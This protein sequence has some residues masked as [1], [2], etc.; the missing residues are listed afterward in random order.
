MNRREFMAGAGASAILLPGVA[1]ALTPGQRVTLLGGANAYDPAA[2]AFFSRLTTPPTSARK[3][4]YNNFFK[5]LR[6]AGLLTKG[7]FCYLTAAADN[8]AARQNLLANQY[9][10]T[11][12]SSP[13]FTADQGYAGDGA[14]A[15]LDTNSVQSSFGNAKQNSYSLFVWSRTDVAADNSYDS[16]VSNSNNTGVI[17]K[18]STGSQLLCRTNSTTPTNPS[19]A[20]SLGF[21]GWTRT[22][23]TTG[24]VYKNRANVASVSSTSAALTAGSI[25]IL[26][27]ASLFSTRQC[28]FAW[29]GAALVDAEVFALYDAVSA[30]LT[31]IGAA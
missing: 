2:A 15:Y 14:A 17:G 3:T 11:A 27:S 23:A 21:Y 20:N 22:G 8:Q 26:G 4:L 29:T 10:A 5:S 9:N 1:E 12:V 19:V 25:R 7:D 6:T 13:T 31:A 16:G 24:A 28:A 30:Y 18:T